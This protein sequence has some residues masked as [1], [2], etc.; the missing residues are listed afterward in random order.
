[1]NADLGLTFGEAESR[2]REHGYNEVAEKKGHPAFD[3]L[4]KFWGISAWM[5]EA[6]IVLS[7]VLRKYAD[8]VVVSGLLVVNAVLGFMQ[9]RRAAG[10][11]ETLRGVY[12]SAHGC[13]ATAT[14]GPFQRAN[15]SQGISSVCV[16]ATSSQPT[17]NCLW[18][19]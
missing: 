13:C 5:L 11:V 12:R 9:E 14:G 18:A 4:K 10:V 3:F 15:W 2:R 1:V 19:I 17:Q 7:A 6:I 8:L 16:S